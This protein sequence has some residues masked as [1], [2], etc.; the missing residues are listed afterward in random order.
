MKKRTQFDKKK[1]EKRRFKKIWE[2]NNCGYYNMKPCIKSF[3][4]NRKRK[5]K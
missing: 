4:E 3:G 1:E 2:Q 5:N